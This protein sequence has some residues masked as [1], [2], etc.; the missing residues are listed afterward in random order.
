MMPYY[1]IQIQY[2]A[3]AIIAVGLDLSKQEDWPPYF[4]QISHVTTSIFMLPSPVNITFEERLDGV[5]VFFFT[6]AAAI[7]VEDFVQWTLREVG[8]ESAGRSFP[9]TLF[10]Y[11]WVTAFFWHSLPHI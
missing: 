5:V 3:F 10:G 1:M 2:V 8:L 4:G 11:V 6:Q 7:T 9:K